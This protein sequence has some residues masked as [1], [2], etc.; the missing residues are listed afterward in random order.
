[1]TPEFG[2]GMLAMGLIA[3]A[4]G[5]IIAYFIIKKVHDENNTDN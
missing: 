3:I 4:I 2:F 1:L 5:A